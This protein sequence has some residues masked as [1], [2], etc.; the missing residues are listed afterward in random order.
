MARYGWRVPRGVGRLHHGLAQGR[1][2]VDRAA[3][4]VDR[5][6][7]VDGETQLGDHLGGVAA[8]DVRTEDLPVRFT[9]MSFTKPS[10]SP[11]A[12]ALPLAMNGNLPTLNLRPFSLARAR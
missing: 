5:G 10:E 1:V 3:D 11:V 4:L 8:D 7:E 2:R 12:S 9:T 6:L